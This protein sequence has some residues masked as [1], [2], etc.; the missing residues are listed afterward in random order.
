MFTH[1]SFDSRYELFFSNCSI[2]HKM[3]LER[4]E[5]NSALVSD[6]IQMTTSSACGMFLLLRLFVR[7]SPSRVAASSITHEIL[8]LKS[9]DWR[10]CPYMIILDGLDGFILGIH[11]FTRTIFSTSFRRAN[12]V[13]YTTSL[14]KKMF[15]FS[16]SPKCF[17]NCDSA[18]LQPTYSSLFKTSV[19]IVVMFVKL[20]ITESWQLL[21]EYV[22]G[23]RSCS[24][25]YNL[26]GLC[27]C[28]VHLETNCVWT[29][30]IS[31][32]IN[33]RLTTVIYAA[34]HR[35]KI[36]AV[37]VKLFSWS[38]WINMETLKVRVFNCINLTKY[39]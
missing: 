6:K 5:R 17:S 18:R 35:Q 30:A 2:L 39:W 29:A 34:D 32:L 36:I 23:S 26:C 13:S 8:M 20:W 11:Q 37:F 15:R 21:W 10:S 7:Q 38:L 3:F 22:S 24:R 16:A 1:I 27:Y 9:E 25:E 12:F 19:Q 28:T 4:Q 14:W 33:M 31:G